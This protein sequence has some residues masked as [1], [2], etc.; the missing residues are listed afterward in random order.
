MCHLASRA[1]RSSLTIGT[2]PLSAI[3][4]GSM[5]IALRL[6]GMRVRHGGDQAHVLGD[7]SDRPPLVPLEGIFW[8]RVQRRA[9]LSG[10]RIVT[11]APAPREWAGVE[12][13]DESPDL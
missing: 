4:V 10:E 5:Y 8:K 1:K 6:A 3:A 9:L 2:V 11:A 13:V 7:D 12:R